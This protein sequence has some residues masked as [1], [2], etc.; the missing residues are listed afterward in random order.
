MNKQIS[1]ASG[2]TLIEL[3]IVVAIIGILASLALPSY[4]DYI[5]RAKLAEA[6]TLVDISKQG[7]GEYY[8]RWGRLPKDNAAAGLFPPEAYRGRYVQSMEVKEGMIR[9][10]VRLDESKAQGY[11]IYL[12][13]ALLEEG[14]AGVLAWVCNG[15]T[16]DLAKGFKVSG[17]VGA[18]VP[19]GKYQSP[20][21]R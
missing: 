15:N 4:G 12:R 5:M 14:S 9:V 11:S 6:L 7:V 19:P 16:T 17:A 3:M 18:D 13:P 21:C 8:G 10:G 20:P 1:G 2:F